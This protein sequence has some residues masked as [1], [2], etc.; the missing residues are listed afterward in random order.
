MADA[1]AFL[2][3]PVITPATS[4]ATAQV[5]VVLLR[6]S[7]HAEVRLLVEQGSEARTLVFSDPGAFA[8]GFPVL[9]LRADAPATITVQVIDAKGRAVTH[10]EPLVFDPEPLPVDKRDFPPVEVRA[11]D[12]ARM[13]PG[14][15]ILAVRRRAIGRPRDLTDRQRS[16]MLDW[17]MLIALDAQG[18]VCWRHQLPRRVAG[19]QRLQS[20]N[21]FYHNADSHSSEIDM[22]GRVQAQWFARDRP[23]GPA[24]GAIPIPVQ[25][26]HHQPHQMPNGN[27]LAL[28]GNARLAKDWYTSEFDPDAP[29]ADKWIVG[30]RILEFTREGEIVWSWDAFDHLDINRIGY[31]A[32]EAYWHVRG[33]PEHGDWTHGNGVCYDERDDS[34]IVSLRLQD[35]LFK[36]DRKSGQIKWILGDHSDWSPELQAKLLTPQGEG[37]RWPWHGHNPRVTSDGTIVMFDNGIL[38]ARPFTPPKAPHETFSRGVEYLVDEDAMTVREVWT[39]ARDDSAVKERTWAMGDAHRLEESDTMLVIHSICMPDRDDMSYDENN[40]AIRHPDDFAS[41]ARIL[42]YTRTDEPEILFDVVIEDPHEIMQWE[43]FGGLR[44]PSLYAPDSG[45]RELQGNELHAGGVV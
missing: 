36:I 34:V 13:A 1:I 21:L 12:P 22:L 40:P 19:I 6:A 43:V 29:R 41:S 2:E 35:A 15:T 11:S 30:D 42:E 32:L 27:F 44:T 20:G 33:F 5:A 16:F 3:N 45:V 28:S 25:T 37:F 8:E 18:R 17:S 26:L 39:S 31:N 23:A 10:P 38:G 4:A 7:G 24:P 14:Y 9:G